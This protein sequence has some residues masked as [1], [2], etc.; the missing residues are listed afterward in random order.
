M[1][2]PST[3]LERITPPK[4]FDYVVVLENEEQVVELQPDFY[5]WLQ[6]DLRGVV[7]TA[8]RQNVDFVNR[9]FFSIILTH[10]V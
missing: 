1:D 8:P 10:Q 2:F 9:S 5:Q 3:E 6:L 7:V 4:A